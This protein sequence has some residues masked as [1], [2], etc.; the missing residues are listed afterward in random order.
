MY[1]THEHK[2]H[3]QLQYKYGKFPQANSAKESI[4][5]LL[6]KHSEPIVTRKTYGHP[7]RFP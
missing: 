7:L 4:Q 6:D 2:T 3:G 1:E 5:T